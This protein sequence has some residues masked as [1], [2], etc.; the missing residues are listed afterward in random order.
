MVDIDIA[1]V[2]VIDSFESETLKDTLES[3]LSTVVNIGDYAVD[4]SRLVDIKVPEIGK[5]EVM[6]YHLFLSRL[7]DFPGSSEE[8]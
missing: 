4:T 2:A 5:Y 6:C 3:S 1:S 7:P 8:Q